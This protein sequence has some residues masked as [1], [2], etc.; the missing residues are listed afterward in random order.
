MDNIS[1]LITTD[2][3]NGAAGQDVFLP[4]LA[5]DN[6]GMNG[7]LSSMA[8]VEVC[9]WLWWHYAAVGLTTPSVPAGCCVWS[10]QSGGHDFV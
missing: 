8:T 9:K 1:G 5:Y 4:V 7:S 6:Y 2:G 10:L 3:Y